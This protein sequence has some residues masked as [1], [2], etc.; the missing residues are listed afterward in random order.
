LRERREGRFGGGRE[1]KMKSRQNDNKNT[2]QIRI[3]KGIHKQ[4]K[5]E[6]AKSGRSIKDVVE[7]CI[8]EFFYTTRHE[9]SSNP[10]SLSN[11]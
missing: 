10:I 8:G 6:A 1:E 9:G 7:E 2:M 3:D 11:L 4:L 5:I